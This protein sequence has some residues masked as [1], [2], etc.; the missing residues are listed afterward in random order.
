MAFL[1]LVAAAFI[2]NFLLS[3]AA[4]VTVAEKRI[5]PPALGI[6]SVE[7]TAQM[8][9]PTDLA[10]ETGELH[11]EEPRDRQSYSEY[12]TG[13][14]NLHAYLRHEQDMQHW[15]I[16]SYLESITSDLTQLEYDNIPVNDP[17]RGYATSRRILVCAQADVFYDKAMLPGLP[18]P[19]K[20]FCGTERIS[21]EQKLVALEVATDLVQ[22]SDIY[23]KDEY[24]HQVL[25]NFSANELND[26]QKTL[27]EE[28]LL[29]RTII[30]SSDGFIENIFDHIR[31]YKDAPAK[32]MA[33]FLHV[34]DIN[35]HGSGFNDAERAR[36]NYGY[37]QFLDQVFQRGYELEATLSSEELNL[38][39]E[40]QKEFF[41]DLN[42]DYDED[43]RT[44]AEYD[45]T[46]E[47]SEQPLRAN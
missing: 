7:S 39:Y 42:E 17:T 5:A 35:P 14:T 21:H 32:Q 37:D 18:P 36:G 2:C 3:N 46:I 6:D 4:Q 10:N 12:N 16:M 15:L 28:A 40:Y 20:E 34:R 43:L 9:K 13:W 47:P 26:I 8:Q 33:G 22:N 45:G 23:T 41:P 30:A 1:A 25:K 19:H 29:D 24:L 38:A 44:F 27:V 11:G 31:Y